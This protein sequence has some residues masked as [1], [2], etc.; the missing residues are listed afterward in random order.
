[1]TEGALSSVLGCYVLVEESPEKKIKRILFSRDPPSSLSPLAAEIVD[2]LEGRGSP[3]ADLDYSGLT[4]FQRE[5]LEAV[6]NIPWGE[7]RTYGEVAVLIGKPGGARAVGRALAANPFP[8]IVPCHRVL[9]KN[10][11]GGFAWGLQLKERLLQIERGS[12]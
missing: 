4:E 7:T 5:V 8:I 3:R 12:L 9:S 6:R 2:C 10:G 11:L 1:M